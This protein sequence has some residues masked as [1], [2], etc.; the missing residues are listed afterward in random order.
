M[1]IETTFFK[2]WNDNKYEIL[3]AN[4]NLD[5]PFIQIE[6][7]VKDIGFGLI[8]FIKKDDGEIIIDS[9]NMDRRFIKEI[10]NYIVDHTTLEYERVNE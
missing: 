10:L 7:T 4:W 3:E 9:E 6:W 2:E 5:G 8:T 1:T